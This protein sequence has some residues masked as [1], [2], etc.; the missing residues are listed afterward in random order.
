MKALVLH[1]V[2]D[3]RY[4]EV[5]DP[6]PQKGEVLLRVEAAGICG[7]DI[8]RV[9]VSGTYSFP[10][11]PGHEFAGCVVGL[12]EGVDQSYMGK[13]AAV[14]PLIPC[15]KCAMCEVGQ[16]A[17]CQNYDYFGSRRD[18]GFAQ[19]ICVPVWNLV[20]L[21]DGLSYE[22]AAMCEPSS[23]AIH[24]LRQQGVELGDNVAIFGAGPIGLMLG[25]WAKIWGAKKVMLF[26]ID[27]AKLGFAREIGF[28]HAYNTR[29][30]APEVYVNEHTDGVGADLVI[31]GAGVSDTFA[32]AVK[33]A[34]PFG[35][36]VCMGN[37]AGDMTLPKAVYSSLLRKQLSIAGTWNSSYA[38]MHKNEWKMSLEA[39][40][41]GKLNVKRL[42]THRMGLE[43]GLKPF[44]MMCARK[45]F[46][47]KVMFFPNQD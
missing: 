14:F 25:L 31:E 41:E 19:Y 22:E 29:D 18:G 10:T 11:I 7:S 20:F 5:A 4:E 12:G 21:P 32:S 37:P 23:V 46:F 30:T 26:D 47:N 28:T 42:V 17:Q 38:A 43:A 15:R 34:R 8:G 33:V 9:L 36:I 35:R 13:R 6:V 40:A 45:E 2:G 16:Y 3:L 39:M 44:E 1:A 27:G 24:A